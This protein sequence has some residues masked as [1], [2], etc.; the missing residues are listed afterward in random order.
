MA[1]IN[2]LDSL[3]YNRIAAGQVIERPACI[4]KELVEN[5]LDGGAKNISIEIL[6]GGKKLIKVTD[7]GEGIESKDLENAFKPHA[8]SKISNLSDLENIN[9]LGFRGEALCSIASICSVIMKSKTKFESVGACVEVQGGKII[10]QSECALNTGTQVECQNIFFNIPARLKFLKVDKTEEGEITDM[11]Q[12]F[13]LSNPKIAFKYKI[14]NKIVFDYFSDNLQDAMYCVYGKEILDNVIKIDYSED[15]YSVYGYIGKPSYLKSNR[16]YQL[17]IVNG[18]VVNNATISSA[19]SNAYGDFLL[20]RRYPFFVLNLKIDNN[21]LDVNVHPQ[22]TEVRFT[23]NGKVYSIFYNS[24]YKAL[25]NQKD[26]GFT[27][28]AAKINTGF[29]FNKGFQKPKIEFNNYNST[30]DKLVYKEEESAALQN[31]FNY[32]IKPAVLE[33]KVSDSENIKKTNEESENFEQQD[34]AIEIIPPDFQTVFKNYQ[35]SLPIEKT[36][37]KIVGTIF[38]T[39]IIIESQSEIYF[40]DQHAAMERII[41][42]KYK[43]S[44]EGELAVQNTLIPY[45]LNVNNLENNY[46]LENLEVFK[47]LGFNIEPFFNNSFKIDEVPHIFSNLDFE[48]FFSNF[49]SDLNNKNIK[50]ESILKEK[51]MQSACKASIKAGDKLNEN[52][53]AGLLNQLK[54]SS[55]FCPHGRPVVIKYS[56][57]EI[58]KWFKRIV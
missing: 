25:N 38:D 1:K 7:D 35:T 34:S 20:K 43:E 58:E 15:N 30:D 33:Y 4:V 39:Y 17:L 10:N 31:D 40:I 29:D 32:D 19:T 11:V 42:D 37:T 36:E 2:L 6:Q 44:L 56:K 41:Y 23:D 45:I 13:I 8:T 26:Q 21:L 50:T 51:L 24:I 54:D 18:R 48:R 16:S 53:I 47:K 22:K 14:D 9:T 55:L 3:I 27:S 12:K 57:Y 5:S 52:D 28:A 49:L 46:I